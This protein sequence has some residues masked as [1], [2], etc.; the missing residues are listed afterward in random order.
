[1]FVHVCS[2]TTS[3][4]TISKIIYVYIVRFFFSNSAYLRVSKC[5]IQ[6]IADLA[7]GSWSESMCFIT[8]DT[9]LLSRSFC[10]NGPV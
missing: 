2:T 9:A 8:A 7:T 1:M 10:T 5:V 3:V 4:C 6:V